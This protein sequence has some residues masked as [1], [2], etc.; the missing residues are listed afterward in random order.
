MTQTHKLADDQRGPLLRAQVTDGNYT[1]AWLV[2]D[3][4]DGAGWEDDEDQVRCW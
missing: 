2:A 3:E 4:E 1:V